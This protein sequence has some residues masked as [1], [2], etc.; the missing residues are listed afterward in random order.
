MG[1][2]F[3]ISEVKEWLGLYF[4]LSKGLFAGTFYLLAGFHALHVFSGMILQIFM[5]ISS[6]IRGNCNKC[7]VGVSAT[8]LFWHFVDVIWVRLFSLIYLWKA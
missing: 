4:G 7:H 6:F 1:A 3:L 2:Y 8:T 5:L